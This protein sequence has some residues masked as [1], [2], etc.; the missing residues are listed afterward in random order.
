MHSYN[1][2]NNYLLFNSAVFVYVFHDK[3]KFNNFKKAT[4]GPRL[5]YSTKV[6]MIKGWGEISL[7][8]RIG[9]Q[10]SILILKKVAYIPNFPL[11]FVSQGCLEDKTY[12]WHH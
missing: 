3:D 1:S 5:L 8:L 12:K 10:I 11:N 7:P 4:Q 6:I 2:A 9:N